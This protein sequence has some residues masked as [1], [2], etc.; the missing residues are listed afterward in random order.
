MLAVGQGPD[1]AAIRARCTELGLDDRVMFTGFRDDAAELM[2]ACDIFTLASRWEGMP[3]AV[4]EALGLGLPIVATSVGGVA[5]SLTDDQDALLVAPG[6]PAALADALQR[7][8]IDGDLRTRLGLA[9]AALAPRFDAAHSVRRIE[10]EYAR[11][12]S[13]SSRTD[14]GPDPRS[15]QPT[16]AQTTPAQPTRARPGGIDIRPATPDDRAA[17][18][19]LCRTSLGWGDDPRFDQLFSWKH[20]QNAFG[21][22]YMWVAT[23]NDLVV[24]VRAFM[25]WE[26]AR[27]GTTLRAVRAVDTAVHPDHQGRGL[28]TALT[29]HALDEVRADGVDFVF[30]TPNDV[31]RPGYIKMGWDVV[32]RVPVVVRPAGLAGARLAARS[33]TAAAH[34]PLDLSCGVAVE[35][36]ASQVASSPA[37]ADVRMLTTNV[38]AEFWRWRYGAAFLGYRAVPHGAGHVVVRLRMRGVARELV[39]LGSTGLSDG[40]VDEVVS[41]TLAHSG[42]THAL[43]IGRPSPQRGW[44]TM[45][46][47]GPVLAWRSVATMA[48]PP[49]SNWDLRLGDIELF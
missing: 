26:F 14:V 18:V 19:D 2:G 6:D 39:V 21:P 33:R 3:V 8:A 29:M 45:P 38:D 28:F 12:A 1:E 30:N 36:V 43:R 16:P 7:V 11:S 34:W 41:S 31:S 20:D 5:E 4:M 44:F 35:E 49:I 42:A 25:R 46:R 32:G 9:S 13:A 27:G 37:D 48:M 23:S 40:D 47:M 24:G 17:I 22:S 15:S 10:E